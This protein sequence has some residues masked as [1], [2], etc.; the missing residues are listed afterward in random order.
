MLMLAVGGGGHHSVLPVFRRCAAP[1]K[2]GIVP[3]GK[4]WVN[5]LKATTAGEL[6]WVD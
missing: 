5:S 4:L 3:F 6:E 1:E 2:I